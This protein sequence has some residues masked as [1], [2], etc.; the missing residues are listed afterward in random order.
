MFRTPPDHE[1][2]YKNI[3]IH[4]YIALQLSSDRSRHLQATSVKV[5]QA[6][7][8]DLPPDI[9]RDPVPHPA[10]AAVAILKT[11]VAK[12]RIPTKAAT[13]SDSKR[14]LWPGVE[15]GVV[16]VA[17]GCSFDVIFVRRGQRRWR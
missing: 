4:C 8:D 7:I 12:V 6:K 1:A 15:F 17:V 11:G 14:P 2:S 10:R 3:L 13:D 16:I 9:I 5:I